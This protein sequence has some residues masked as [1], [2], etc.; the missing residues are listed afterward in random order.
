MAAV[1]N[2]GREDGLEGS[3]LGGCKVGKAENIPELADAQGGGKL[4]RARGV[5]LGVA[6]TMGNLCELLEGHLELGVPGVPRG[7]GAEGKV[8]AEVAASLVGG[9]GRDRVGEAGGVVEDNGKG[10]GRGHG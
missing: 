10:G 4:Y 9:D 8:K 1:D 5:G 6:D 2:S 7:E 3:E